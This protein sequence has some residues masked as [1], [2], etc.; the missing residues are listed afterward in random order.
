MLRVLAVF[1]ASCANKL[2]DSPIRMYLLTLF[3]FIKAII[4]S[5]RLMKPVHEQQKQTD[6]TKLTIDH[7]L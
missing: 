4:D 1:D 5:T 7:V 3:E 6:I 2:D